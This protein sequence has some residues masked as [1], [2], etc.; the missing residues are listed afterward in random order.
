MK[1]TLTNGGSFRDLVHRHEETSEFS[2]RIDFPGQI[3]EEWCRK[4]DLG[5]L[6]SDLRPSRRPP[7]SASG[8]G[9]LTT[10]TADELSLSAIEMCLDGENSPATSFIRPTT[11]F[12][13]IPIQ[14]FLHCAYL[15]RD[16]ISL[17]GELITDSHH[18]RIRQGLRELQ[19]RTTK[20]QDMAVRLENERQKLYV[21]ERELHQ[22]LE[23]LEQRLQ[24]QRGRLAAEQEEVAKE[25]QQSPESLRNG[26]RC[27]KR[28]SG[29]ANTLN[30]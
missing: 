3:F 5:D 26:R 4:Y 2:V 8:S 28:V 23:I 22:E 15:M 16:S 9:F 13:P 30:R 7:E 17:C 21:R 10:P 19:S 18:K 1:G 11:L 24:E 20:E 12:G 25:M 14:S 29:N 27:S 6:T